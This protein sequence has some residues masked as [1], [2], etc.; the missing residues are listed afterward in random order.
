MIRMCRLSVIAVGAVL[1]G[2]ASGTAQPPGTPAPARPA[3]SPYLNLLRP[4]NSPGVNY[5][6]LVRP[7]LVAQQQFGAI[8]Q[9]INTIQTTMGR[10]M[11]TT[12]DLP[13]TGQPVGFL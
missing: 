11:T 8:Q 4:A 9:Q 6:G 3:F 12:T 1:I 2:S 10:S 5:Y 13:E 7:Q